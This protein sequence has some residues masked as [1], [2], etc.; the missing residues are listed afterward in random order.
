MSRSS[1]ANTN[2]FDVLSHDRTKQRVATA[3]LTPT[4]SA[5]AN[6]NANANANRTKKQKPPKREASPAV[7]TPPT[8]HVSFNEDAAGT[9]FVSA[10][11]SY[12]EIIFFFKKRKLK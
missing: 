2:P 9:A 1:T 4:V 6:A 12:A 10:L 7:H 11:E 5:Y 3:A 8:L